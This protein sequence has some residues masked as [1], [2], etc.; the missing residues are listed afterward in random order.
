M[1]IKEFEEYNK[2]KTMPQFDIGQGYGYKDFDFDWDKG[3]MTDIIYI[4]EYG[5]EDIIYSEQYDRDPA[6][7]ECDVERANAY[8]AQDLL[9]LCD[10]IKAKARY[11]FSW[12]D[13]QYPETGLDDMEIVDEGIPYWKCEF[14]GW[15]GHSYEEEMEE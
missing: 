13:W 5:Y 4:P 7:R 15:D 2:T 6:E 12:I 1:T 10:G 9:N 14:W 3:N 11:L 8:S